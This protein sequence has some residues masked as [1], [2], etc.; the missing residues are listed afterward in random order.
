MNNL[1]NSSHL[2]N[3]TDDIVNIF[4]PQ[5]KQVKKDQLLKDQ[6]FLTIL[7]NYLAEAILMIV[8]YF[9]H[10]NIDRSM[11]DNATKI[12]RTEWRSALLADLHSLDH[13]T[14]DLHV[15]SESGITIAQN[16]NIRSHMNWN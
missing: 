6:S 16:I 4:E 2:R 7:K 3:C 12:R 1:P 8:C 9:V 5:L 11:Y 10:K 14:I 15:I 13:M